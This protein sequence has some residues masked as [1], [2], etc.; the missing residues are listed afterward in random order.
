MW[1]KGEEH[2]C[3]KKEENKMDGEEVSLEMLQHLT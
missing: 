3:K 2:L 1:D